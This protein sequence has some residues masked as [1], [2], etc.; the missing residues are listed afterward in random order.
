MVRGKEVEGEDEKK[1]RIDALQ[2]Q[3]DNLAAQLG[4]KQG[5]FS[6]HGSVSSA[7]LSTHPPDSPRPHHRR[8]SSRPSDEAS[9]EPVLGGLVTLREAD[10][11]MDKFRTQKMA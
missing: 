1:T 10:E 2:E 7:T 6:H 8:E 3:I 9:G 11:L 4:Q 5:E